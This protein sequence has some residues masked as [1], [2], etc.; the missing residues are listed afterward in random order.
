[1]AKLSFNNI[2]IA[3]ISACVPRIIERNM[4]YDWISEEE[5]KLLIKTTGIAE[6]RKA[7]DGVVTSDL[8][9]QTAEKLISELQWNKEE[10]EALVFVS[11]S[12][13]YL[14]PATSVILQHRLG[15]TKNCLAFDVGLGCSGY[16]YGLSVVSGLL[17]S[18]QIKKALLLAGDATDFSRPY[19][20]KSVYP[21]FGDA[22]T[23]TA[24]EYN[25]SASPAYFNL[26]SDGSG[27]ESIIIY[28]GL[29]RN[30]P[31]VH[32]FVPKEIEKGIERRPM[33]VVLNG[34]AV[35]DFSLREVPPSIKKT[36]AF[37]HTA[38]DNIDYFV[39]H[40]ANLLMNETVRKLMKLP[41]E[42]FPYSLREFGNTSS[43]S[44]PLT[45]VTQLRQQVT[46]KQLTFLFSGFGV[47]LSWGTCILQTDKIVCPC[48]IEYNV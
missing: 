24:M 17:Q 36:I 44:I 40:Q 14:L 37:A 1:M 10:I 18:G 16:V 34:A 32:S 41:S 2:R 35:F 26:Q 20:D 46:E 13:D 19:K 30:S 47:G 27:F 29:A 43:A 25:P 15:L 31:S 12:G 21:L 23:A 33:D 22:G 7:P 3:G 5:R 38:A 4:D 28:D 9:F 48:L 6:R 39:L 42:K 8:C 45:I 11:Q